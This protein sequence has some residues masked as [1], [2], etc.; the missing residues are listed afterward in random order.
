MTDKPR[1]LTNSS[2]YLTRH[3]I[4]RLQ[5]S[6]QVHTPPAYPFT[7]PSRSAH[8]GGLRPNTPLLHSYKDSQREHPIVNLVDRTAVPGAL[9]QT[10]DGA[11]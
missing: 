7:R 8:A 1:R 6:S 10:E 2:Y 11:I 9:R 3:L 4:L 5:S